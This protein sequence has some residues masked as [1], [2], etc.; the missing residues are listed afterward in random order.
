MKRV[1]CSLF[2]VVLIAALVPVASLAAQAPD[3]CL[4]GYTDSGAQYAICIPPVGWNGDLILFAHGYVSPEDPVGLASIQGQLVLP[5]GTSIPALVGGLGFAFATTSYRT[6]GLAVTEG[7]LDLYELVQIF[8]AGYYTQTGMMYTGRI[9][10]MGAS[11]GALIATLSVENGLALFGENPYTGVMAVCGPVGDFS[12]QVNYWG[13]FRVVFDYFFPK[14]LPPTAVSIPQKVIDNWD[15]VY[16]PKIKKAIAAKPLATLQLLNVT[17]A[18][19]N[20]FDKTTIGETVLG[21]LWYNAF[22]TNDGVDKLGGQPFDNKTVKYSGSLNDM[23]LNKTVK[24][25]TADPAALAMIDAYHQTSGMPQAPLVNLHTTGDP[26]VPYWHALLYGQKVA[27]NGYGAIYTHLPVLAYGH[28]SFTV[29]QVLFGF[30]ILMAQ[31]GGFDMAAF[32]Q[33][34]DTPAEAAEFESLLQEF[35]VGVEK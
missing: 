2:V 13:D 10:L 16:V 24:R 35:G 9:Y 18:P 8:R 7:I 17:K 25:Y 6:N 20:P 26:I 22:A 15:T 14:V 28:C 31:T 11:E 19:Y 12:K 33:A 5:D 1:F 21:I 27:D 3:P 34:M 29:P 30:S 4:Y 23:R 32:E